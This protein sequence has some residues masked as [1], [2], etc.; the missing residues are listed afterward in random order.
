MALRPRTLARGQ[1]SLVRSPMPIIRLAGCASQFPG[2]GC[3]VN[4]CT[5]SAPSSGGRALWFSRRKRW[6]FGGIV[7]TAQA[8]SREAGSV[9]R[10]G[11]YGLEVG[12]AMVPHPYRT[13]QKVRT[14]TPV[15][16]EQN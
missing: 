3:E 12:C 7:L 13:P 5:P 4:D 11:E 9:S 15:A 8:G 14:P 1:G 6:G 2:P 16:P 10:R